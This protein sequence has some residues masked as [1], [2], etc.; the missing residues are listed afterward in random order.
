MRVYRN[1]VAA[2]NN[3]PRYEVPDWFVKELTAMGGRDTLTGQPMLRIVFGQSRE[4]MEFRCGEWRFRYLLGFANCE[5]TQTMKGREIEI[6]GKRTT[7]QTPLV[8]VIKKR[9]PVGSPY[10]FIEPF[11]PAH[12]LCSKEFWDSNIR[13]F[14]NSENAALEDIMGEYPSRGY[15]KP[16]WRLVNSDFSPA[17]PSQKVLDEIKIRWRA[18]MADEAMTPEELVAR[19]DIWDKEQ[20]AKEA[21]QFKEDLVAAIRD[22]KL[23]V[24]GHSVSLPGAKVAAGLDAR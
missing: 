22:I 16:G 9:E 3:S 20:E 14:F 12:K 6:N 24:L 18:M 11:V 10:Y 1:N 2:L 13:W 8:G 21:E 5:F 15:Y 23:Q 7:M 19:E 4:S 17:K